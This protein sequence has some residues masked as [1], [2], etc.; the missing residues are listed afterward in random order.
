[1]PMPMIVMRINIIIAPV[2]PPEPLNLGQ[3]ELKELLAADQIQVSPDA[4]VLGSEALE[5]TAEHLLA[6]LGLDLAREAGVKVVEHL[7]VEE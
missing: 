5:P 6:Q 1:M 4:G 3:H 2:K 7:D